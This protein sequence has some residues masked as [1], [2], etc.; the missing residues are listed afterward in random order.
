VV[1]DLVYRDLQKGKYVIVDF[2]AGRRPGGDGDRTQ[3]MLYGKFIQEAFEI[4]LG[5]IEL[6][7]EYLQDGISV[8]YTP[9][10]IDFTNIDYL[11]QTSMELMYT[12]L[13][14]EEQNTPKEIEAFNQTE[15]MSSCK[16]CNFKELCGRI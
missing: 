9:K 15:N 12:Y 13:Q 10:S 3:L 7:N 5:Q 16:R 4:D 11:L 14:D 6:R 2:K 1:L 8:T